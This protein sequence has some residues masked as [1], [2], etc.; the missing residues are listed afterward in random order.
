VNI[1]LFALGFAIYLF[2]LFVLVGLFAKAMFDCKDRLRAPAYGFAILF[3]FS[4]L[5]AFA[6]GGPYRHL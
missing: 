4:L 5:I 6:L 3:M 2:I 1:L